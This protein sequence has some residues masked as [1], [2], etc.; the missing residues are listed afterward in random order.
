M[1]IKLEKNLNPFW[2]KGNT[3]VPRFL[4]RTD[5]KYVRLPLLKTLGDRGIENELFNSL[6]EYLP[7]GAII[8]GGFMTSLMQGDK[9]AN[10]VDFFFTSAKAFK[11]TAELFLNPP[12]D[13]EAWAY[14]GYTLDPST[15]T[16]LF[17]K[18]PGLVRFLKFVHPKR[19][20]VQLVKLVWYDNAEHVVDSF[21]FTVAQFAAD[22]NGDLV[23]NPLSI[24]DLAR[25]KLVL[26]RIQFPASTLRRLI[27]YTNKG[28]YACP[29][30]LEK[31]AEE[32]AK[33]IT[34]D[35]GVLKGYVYLD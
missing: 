22:S 1:L 24:F 14:Q 30:S 2:A 21:D 27:K 20:P 7:D 10:D 11:E 4:T 5:A 8:A 33:A 32:S 31:I 25:K 12:A 26:H 19:L 18:N 23:F 34:E 16:D 6:Y 17:D 35:E 28:Y 3:E 15:D 9:Q 29:G 13:T